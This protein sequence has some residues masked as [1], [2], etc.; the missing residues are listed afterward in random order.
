MHQIKSKH[1][2]ARQ[3]SPFKVHNIY[4]IVH[5]L[6]LSKFQ[7]RLLPVVNNQA[8]AGIQTSLSNWQ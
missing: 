5:N 3:R 2:Q 6:I 4:I 7:A 1:R 8:G